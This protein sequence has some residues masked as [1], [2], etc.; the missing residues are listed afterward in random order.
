WSP[1][2]RI[3]LNKDARLDTP[4]ARFIQWRAVLKPANPSTL[5]DEVSINYLPK[6]VAPVVEDV[7]V[8]VGFRYPVQPHV[9]AADA[10]SGILG[11][12]PPVSQS[13]PTPVRDRGSVAVH[14][15]ARDENEDN[16]IYSLYYRGDAER[17]WKLLKSGI[18]DKFYSFDSGLLPDGGYQ[19]KVAASD[20][21]SHTPDEALSDEKESQRF[22][23]DNTPP[24][25]ENLAARLEG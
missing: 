9:N 15:S 19:V 21:P 25:I 5:L 14:W 12:P 1:W 13:L 20:A 11:S 8:Q 2:T 23:V 24:R 3:D 18:S 6:N 17:D 22:D 10:V 16:L 4:S 7:T